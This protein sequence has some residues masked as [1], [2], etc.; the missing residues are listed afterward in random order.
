MDANEAFDMSDEEINDVL[1]FFD[2]GE[3]LYSTAGEAG[4]SISRCEDLLEWF[5]R[6]PYDNE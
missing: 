6:D 2:T 1:D 3:S 4:L 5:G